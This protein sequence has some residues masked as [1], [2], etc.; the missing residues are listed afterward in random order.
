MNIYNINNDIQTSFFGRYNYHMIRLAPEYIC[1]FCRC[2]YFFFR[3]I[4]IG[5]CVV[6]A[7][8]AQTT[9]DCSNLYYN[10]CDRPSSSTEQSESGS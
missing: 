4:V 3:Y 9:L 5:S 8:G 1:S 7:P 6:C 2:F 10:Y